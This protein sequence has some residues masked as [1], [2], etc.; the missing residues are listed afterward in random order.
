VTEAAFVGR[1]AIVD[2]DRRVV[3]YEL[4]YRRSRGSVVA[5]YDERNYAAARVI[6]NTFASLG[7]ETVLGGLL[8]FF[9]VTRAVL[10]SEAV[11]ALPKERVVIELLEDIEPDREVEARCRALC[12]AGYTLA[13]D[14]WIV[15]DPRGKL[16]PYA[17]VVKVDLPRVERR[18]WRRLARTLRDAGKR[19]LAEKVE[20]QDEFEACLAAGFARFQGYFFARPV[21][22]EGALLD[23]AQ[24]TLVRLLQQI[25]VGAETAAIV[26]SLKQDAKLGVNLIRLVN[27][28]GSATRVRLESIGDGVR[29]MGLQQL[30]RW[31]AVLLFAQ[32][33]AGGVRDPLLTLAAHRG[34]LMELVA[35]TADLRGRI[36]VDR[37]QA[38]LVGMLSLVDALFGRPIDEIVRELRLGPD[39]EGAL[40]RREGELGRLLTLAEAVERGDV[41]AIVAE[42]EYLGLSLDELQAH[43][44]AAYAWIHSL[45]QGL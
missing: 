20:T 29:H 36:R 39:I 24:T 14:D 30:S 4:L 44:H 34:R 35:G 21:V 1:Q 40:I 28:A 13:L 5:D 38:F 8:G 23:P 45:Q 37:E 31:I 32:G 11:H 33:A 7:E 22:L 43:E 3:A 16:L 12:E 10:L 2:R 15:D 25:S 41:D 17:E 18:H 9:N 6:A 26:E 42:Q 19:T 27:T